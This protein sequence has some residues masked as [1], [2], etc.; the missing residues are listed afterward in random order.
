V[1]ELLGYVAKMEQDS[2]LIF[3]AIEE[4]YHKNFFDKVIHRK[5]GHLFDDDADKKFNDR[6]DI[7]RQ[8]LVGEVCIIKVGAARELDHYKKL[9][10]D[11]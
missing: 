5:Y 10:E 2:F 3:D 7:L 4:V 8:H 11:L 9:S 1:A 6:I